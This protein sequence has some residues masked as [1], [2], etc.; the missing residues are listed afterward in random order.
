[1]GA[2]GGV[3][4]NSNI[5]TD[6]SVFWLVCYIRLRGRDLVEATQCPA[7]HSMLRHRAGVSLEPEPNTFAASHSQLSLPLSQ[8]TCRR[9]SAAGTWELQGRRRASQLQG[10]R[11]CRPRQEATLP[12]LLQRQVLAARPS[13][14]RTSLQTTGASWPKVNIPQHMGAYL[15]LVGLI[16]HTIPPG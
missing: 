10:R 4:C 6:R 12:Q 15:G 11:R 13:N 9:P 3:K 5:I 7:C 16:P 1:M 2:R 14:W 8:E